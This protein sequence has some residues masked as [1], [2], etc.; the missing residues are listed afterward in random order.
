VQTDIE[1]YRSRLQA[2][3][4]A[5]EYAR[6]FER[7]PRRRIDRREQRAVR[8]ILAALPGCHSVLDVP[9][10]AGR[11]LAGLSGGRREVVEMDVAAE[12]LEL[13]RR[14][15]ATLGVA[16]RFLQGDASALP[17]PDGGVDAVFCNRLLHH[18]PSAAQRAVFLRQFHRVARRWVIVSFFDYRRLGGLR[19][20]L[21]RLK[22]RQVDYTG[23]PTLEEFRE[24][25]RQCGFVVREVA[26][27][28]PIWVAE[29][30][31]V[32]GKA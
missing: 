5:E 31:V 2:T 1:A 22:G 29:K 11:F 3:E 9:C 21:K 27:T 6:R 18:I 24:E 23:Q 17:L 19:R 16:A 26:P 32:L 15:A 8:R 10:G 25:T 28:G 13:A 4:R 7:G 12:V 20:L 30:Y 14:R